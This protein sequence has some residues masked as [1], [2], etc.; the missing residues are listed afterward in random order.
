[1]RPGV[2]TALQPQ[3]TTPSRLWPRGVEVAT[4][5]LPKVATM[6]KSTAAKRTSKPAAY[7][8]PRP[9]FPL[10]PHVR[11]RQWCKKVKGRIIYFGRLDDP[12]AALNKWLDERDD[13]LAG[14]T[15]RRAKPDELTVKE[16][17][18]R[19]LTTKL[20]LV[21]SGEMANRTWKDY[22]RVAAKL[23]D[24]FGRT[25]AVADLRPED[26]ERLRSAVAK[27]ERGEGVGPVA[28]GNF[29]RRIKTI[30]RYALDNE[31]IDRPVKI[32]QGFKPPSRQAMRK[33]RNEQPLRMFKADE[34]RKIIN[35]APQPLRAMVLLGASA[36]L[37]N[38]DIGQ[39]RMTHVDLDNAVLVYP[40][41]KTHVQRK[42]Y[43]WP[44]TVAAM[45]EWLTLR[46]KAKV[47]VDDLLMFTT[48]FG[49]A[50]HNDSFDSPISK[51]LRKLLNELGI[52]RRGLSFYGLR[53]GFETIAGQTR[54][55]PAVDRIMGHAERANDMAAV[56][57]QE[58][59]DD[60]MDE[61]LRSVSDHV[62]LWLFPP[63]KTP[64]G[65]AN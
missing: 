7:P 6:P 54:D 8:K 44:E 47:G 10:T 33:L 31:L 14:R 4:I 22:E 51:E 46:P 41:P 12:E 11:A 34:L 24:V 26:F 58:A 5:L 50:W 52:N 9:D 43:L 42:A 32:G 49:N 53:R 3:E 15:P 35:A 1:M 36:G 56:Y 21:E 48:K 60:T 64:K 2:T 23:V 61:R 19:F 62:R 63:K 30:F 55:Q 39:M 57:R 27:G 16:L 28:I 65:K 37:G 40:R 20:Q 18:N 38:S 29:L 59:G 13:L 17:V 25:R 45:R